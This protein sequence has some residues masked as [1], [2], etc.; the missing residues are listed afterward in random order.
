MELGNF[1]KLFIFI[2]LFFLLL[3]V[4]L[5]IGGKIPFLGRLPGDIMLER[6]NFTLYFPIVT[7]ALLSIIL[8][9]LI[10]LFNTVFRK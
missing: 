9:I 2:G 6:K 1:A 10:W 3:G 4:S 7:C 8:T 5:F